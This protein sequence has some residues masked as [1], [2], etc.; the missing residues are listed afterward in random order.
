M[1]LSNGLS[2]EDKDNS[3]DLLLRICKSM[4]HMARKEQGYYMLDRWRTPL[5]LEVSDFLDSWIMSSFGD[6]DD[7]VL[8]D[9]T[10]CS[11]SNARRCLRRYALSWFQLF[12]ELRHLFKNGNE[13]QEFYGNLSQSRL[14]LVVVFFRRCQ[15]KPSL[16]KF[17]AHWFYE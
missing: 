12:P 10:E 9:K 13:L 8:F 4:T 5:S 17:T 11:F 1:C 3:E 16:P 2:L 6:V 7:V 14:W 15:M